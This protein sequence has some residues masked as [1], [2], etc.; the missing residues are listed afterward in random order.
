MRRIL[1]VGIGFILLEG[2]ST[3][4]AL[5]PRPSIEPV[6][7][8][9]VWLRNGGE[10]FIAFQNEG[11]VVDF[12]AP[13]SDN[14]CLVLRTPPKSVLPSA[15]KRNEGFAR[16][17]ERIPDQLPGNDTISV[18]N[19]DRASS[20]FAWY[21]EE[22]TSDVPLLVR[23]RYVARWRL[24]FED[25]RPG[26]EEAFVASTA[27]RSIYDAINPAFNL[28]AVDLARSR[29]DLHR[30]HQLALDLNRE[31]TDLA[32]IFPDSIRSS[33][34]TAYL[35]YVDLTRALKEELDFHDTYDAVLAVFQLERET[36]SDPKR[37]IAAAPE[38]TAFLRQE[39]RFPGRIR[40]K[41]QRMFVRPLEDAVKYVDTI[42]LR[43]TDLDPIDSV[44]PLSDLAAA[45]ETPSV[46][47]LGPMV[48]FIEGFNREAGAVKR[49][50]GDILR[51]NAK[52]N[53]QGN[54][55]SAKELA[56]LG[57]EAR[58]AAERLPAATSALI[59]RYSDAVCVR[60]L[61]AELKKSR[62]WAVATESLCERGSRILDDVERHQWSAAESGLIDL[63]RRGDWAAYSFL[64]EEKSRLLRRA[65]MEIFS[66]VRDA[67][68]K[69]AAA[70]INKHEHAYEN[71]SSLYTDSAFIPL[72]LFRFSAAGPDE[73]VRKRSQL[74]QELAR[75][76][77]VQ[78]PEEAIKAIYRDFQGDIRNKGV[79]RARAIVEHG[80]HYQ[81]ADKQVRG[82]VTEC[83]ANAAKLIVK[84]KS[85][86]K[87]YALP[88]ATRQGK[89][90]Y[91]V[92]LLLK[93]PS[94]A[95]FPVFDINM[96]LP[97]EIAARASR[98]QWYKSITVN[99]RPMKNEGRYRITAPTAANNF[100]SLI[101]PVQMDK[102]G[103]NIV[104]VRFTH[105]GSKVFEISAMAQ[106]PIIRKN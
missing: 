98:E 14:F 73:V 23:Y 104:E 103:N 39:Q 78:F 38:L 24:T 69:R 45:C 88:I 43:K 95:Q 85:Y 56:A 8:G 1:V 10:F 3:Y 76:R 12:P 13:P 63:D 48:Q 19:V 26:Y 33:R 100:E 82:L 59:D 70:Y 80:K 54:A 64:A 5:E 46:G 83:D 34:D 106:V 7:N 27:S 57:W 16:S 53:V 20:S 67:A 35:Q 72:Y 62:G 102:N 49:F 61:I 66:E 4:V 87:V 92:R 30:V 32:R 65:D 29:D 90:E 84:A 50:N 52:F 89:S 58:D 75:M 101:S 36:R 37:F 86:R 21:I 2:C 51:I 74:R 18:Y 40:Q 22:R 28:E 31:L 68:T 97:E 71:V 96:K 9:F 11:Y 77:D 60:M 25:L 81:G 6:E 17:G 47:G 79:E 94:N 41:G 44:K 42:I 99:K 15:L 55:L 91:L 93:I 105:P